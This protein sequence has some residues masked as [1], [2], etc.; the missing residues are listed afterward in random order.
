[1]ASPP[2]APAPPILKTTNFNP[3]PPTSP[4]LTLDLLLHVLSRTLFHPFL[5]ALLPLSLRALATPYTAPSFLLTSLFALSVC[6]YRFVFQD[7]NRRVAYGSARNVRGRGDNEEGEGKEE[8]IVITGGAAGLGAC[9]GE[10]WALRGVAVGVLDVDV[11]EGPGGRRDGEEKEGVRYYR[12]DVG[13]W[14]QVKRVWGR[15]VRDLRTPTVLVNNAAV[16][17]GKGVMKQSREEVERTFRIN[18]LSHYQLNRLFLRSLMKGETSSRAEGTIV[19]VSSVLAHLGAAH[20]SAYTAFKA[21]LLAYYASLT[22]ELTAKAPR[23]K[24]ILIAPG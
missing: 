22:A 24:T 14:E 11:G 7:L 4:P 16:V 8:V 6:L 1:M 20:L 19:T 3:P 18:T 13:D 23:V 17:E 10:I 12:C 15:L 5:A 9:L 21:T 2:P